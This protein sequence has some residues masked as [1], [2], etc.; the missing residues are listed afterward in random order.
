MPP[1]PPA[2]RRRIA[3]PARPYLREVDSGKRMLALG[4]AF[5]AVVLALAGVLG[6][7]Y[8][9]LVIAVPLA[10]VA[11]L[12]GWATFWWRDPEPLGFRRTFADLPLAAVLGTGGVLGIAIGGLFLGGALIVAIAV[13]LAVLV[14]VII[15]LHLWGRR[16]SRD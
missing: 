9:L 14:L 2:I 7:T 4:F 15:P 12:N 13:Q 16:G 5:V 8:E 11:L 10:A 6:G 3:G 1:L